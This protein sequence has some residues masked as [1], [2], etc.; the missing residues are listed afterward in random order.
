MLAIKERLMEKWAPDYEDL[1]KLKKHVGFYKRFFPKFIDNQVVRH[2]LEQDIVTDGVEREVSVLFT[3]VRGFTNYSQKTSLQATNSLLNNFY[4]MVIHHT[5]AQ[6]GIVDKFMGDGTMSIFGVYD[7]DESF[8]KRSVVA[9]KAIITDFKEMTSQKHQPD[10]HLG[11]GLSKGP[12][13]VGMFGNGQYVSFTAIGHTVNLAARIQGQS[14]N[15]NVMFTKSVADYIPKS[16]YSPC[17]KYNLKGVKNKV[18]L[19]ELNI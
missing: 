10:L 9:A 8:V 2:Q 4:D 11:V 15:N 12:A 18:Q 14:Q 17:G 13:V 3:D 6:G 7:D 5:Q 16:S 1:K 19:Y